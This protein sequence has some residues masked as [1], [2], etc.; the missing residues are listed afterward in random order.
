MNSDMVARIIK[1]IAS[2]LAVAGITMT[3]TDQTTI[4]AAFGV[5]YGIVSGV[6]GLLA[7]KV[8]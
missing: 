8:G 5:V 3:D 6:Q 4:A 1:A 7:K 2:L